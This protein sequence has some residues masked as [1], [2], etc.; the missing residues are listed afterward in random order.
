[1]HNSPSGCSVGVGGLSWKFRGLVFLP[2]CGS[3]NY[4]V[5]RDDLEMG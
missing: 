5:E 3:A 1:M 2:F 4:C